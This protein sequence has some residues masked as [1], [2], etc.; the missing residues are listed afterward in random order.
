MY[1][2]NFTGSLASLEAGLALL[3]VLLN[4][5]EGEDHDGADSHSAEGKRAPK[6]ARDEKQQLKKLANMNVDM[7]TVAVLSGRYFGNNKGVTDADL[8]RRRKEE[9]LWLRS[10]VATVDPVY[11]PFLMAHCGF[12]SVHDRSDVQ[13]LENSLTAYEAAWTNG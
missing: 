10:M 11:I 9:L 5:E 3:R 4:I 6:A 1:S 13:P 12:H 2:G 7:R 8:V